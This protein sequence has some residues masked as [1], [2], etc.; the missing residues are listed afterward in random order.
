MPMFRVNKTKVGAILTQIDRQE[1]Q[2]LM[3][4]RYGRKNHGCFRKGHVS[5][6]KGRKG[7][8]PA[9]C[10]A[11]QLRAGMIRGAAARKYRPL[12]SVTIRRDQ[13]HHEGGGRPKQ[14]RLYRWIKGKDDGPRR[15]RYIP[16]ARYLWQKAHGPVPPGRFVVH[17]DHDTMNDSLENLILVDRKELM[18]RLYRRP[19]VI[20]KCRRRA[21]RA[22]TR[23]HAENRAGKL[24]RRAA[25]II[26][27]CTDCGH[28]APAPAARC[29][30][31]GGVM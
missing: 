9:G 16:L 10:T 31:C 19:D 2:D 1:F 24:R 12:G 17:A 22:A 11:T 4:R 15:E 26:W 30:K 6:N 28:D 20:A 5:W 3:S 21:A 7:W 23:H 8:C 18:A 14:P 29:S 27:E 25:R 13:D